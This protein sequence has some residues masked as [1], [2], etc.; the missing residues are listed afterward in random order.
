MDLSQLALECFV[1]VI[2]SEEHIASLCVGDALFNYVSECVYYTHKIYAKSPRQ[3]CA[4]LL[5]QSTP[6]NTAGTTGVEDRRKLTPHHFSMH[7]PSRYGV[8]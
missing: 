8:A 5:G 7:P 4:A 6:P 1:F 3:R 2:E